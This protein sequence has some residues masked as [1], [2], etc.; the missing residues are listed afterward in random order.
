MQTELALVGLIAAQQV[1]FMYQI[2]KLVDWTHG[3][4]VPDW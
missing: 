3:E 4:D 1:Y 2:H